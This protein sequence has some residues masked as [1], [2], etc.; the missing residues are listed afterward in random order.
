MVAALIFGPEPETPQQ[1]PHFDFG[2]RN[3]N[4]NAALDELVFR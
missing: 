2:G 3:G 4:A 1:I